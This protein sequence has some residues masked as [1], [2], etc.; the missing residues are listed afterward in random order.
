MKKIITI[1]IS[2]IVLALCLVC[3]VSCGGSI[4]RPTGFTF[5]DETLTIRWNKVIG[6]RSYT[7][8][9]PGEEREKTTKSTFFSI[10]DLDAGKYDIKIRANGEGDSTSDWVTYTVEREAENGLKYSLINNDTEYQVTSAGSAEG[11]IV[12]PATYRGKPVTAIAA[13]AFYNNSKIT[14]IDVGTSVKTIGQKAFTKCSKL[15]SVT[16]HENVTSIG[17]YAFQSCKQLTT[18]TLPESVTEITPFMFSWCTSLET[19]EVGNAV[20]TIGEYAFSSCESLK[21]ISLPDTLTYI[22]EYAFSDCAKLTNL[23][24]AGI[25]E[26][27]S[28]AF[29]NCSSLAELNLGESLVTIH[30]YAFGNCTSIPSIVIPDS[31]VSIK[32]GAF[33]GC[34]SLAEIKL[35]TGLR[36]IGSS[37]FVGTKLY[38]ETTG[39]F[40]IDGWLLEAKDKTITK[41]E[42]PE[43][44]FALADF[45]IS[46]CPDLESISISGVKYVGAG[47][48]YNCTKLWEVIFDDTLV[49]LGE[50]AFRACTF[51]TDVKLSEGLVSIGNYAF[52]GCTRLYTVDLPDS[53]TTVGSYVFHKTLAYNTTTNGIIYMDDWVVG[54]ATPMTGYYPS[55]NIDEGT[56]GI[57]NYSFAAIP[58]IY[59]LMPETLEIIGRGAFYS[60]AYNQTMVIPGNVKYI[61]DY[62]FYN[63][64]NA[65]FG[66]NG[67]TV[68]PEGTEYVGRSAFF[69]C[70]SMV[71]L[72]IPGTVKSIGKF[73]FYNCANLGES[74]L[75]LPDAPEDPL[76]GQ[77]TLGEGIESIG[78]QAFRNCVGLAE[79]TIPN[80]VTYLGNRAFYKCGNLRSVTL[81][82]GTEEILE[83]TFYKCVSLTDLTLYNTKKIGKYAFR[84]CTAMTNLSLD[85][86]EEIGTYA[87]F[88]CTGLTDIR[89]P[90][91]VTSIGTYAFRGC[92]EV[93]SII[94]PDTVASIG[95]HAF[96]GL[97][98]AT[99]YCEADS[100]IAENWSRFFNS[101]NRPVIWGCTLSED[102]SYVVSFTMNKASIAN[103]TA[104]NGISAPARAGYVFDKWSDNATATYAANDIM[105]AQDNTNLYAQWVVESTED[106]L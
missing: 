10:E 70:Q 51:L 31:T 40:H 86:V 49:E 84:G 7:V 12:I 97:N 54:V 36:Q 82:T 90:S 94:I 53:L 37:V 91:S 21:A 101:S 5:D 32:Y 62:A 17:D 87:F 42:L 56:K 11:D 38:E 88:E 106:E 14:G 20:T 45:S 29:F 18:I 99:F 73:A 35:G 50:N 74:N 103:A 75:V 85:G 65:W 19:I 30:N 105:Q 71:G 98:K 58:T 67:I 39:M 64:V 69:N 57:A 13:K 79:I 72:T 26:I 78:D 1:S 100:T 43:G 23:S 104:L 55:L 95:K 41:L 80:S 66:E 68:I 28:Y 89:I 59:L 81:G 8:Q 22:D 102:D 96:Y 25:R 77:V 16:L 4:E 33:M 48:F 63:C 3:F 24:L 93:N 2:L 34:S 15:T 92:T 27:A 9:I 61:G 83:Y 60:C 44:I 76:V 52:Y 46:A 47:A 6:A